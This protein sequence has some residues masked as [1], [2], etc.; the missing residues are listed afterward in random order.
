MTHTS[1]KELLYLLVKRP[2]EREAAGEPDGMMDD[3]KDDFHGC[4]LNVENT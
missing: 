2:R 4:C 1:L 3:L